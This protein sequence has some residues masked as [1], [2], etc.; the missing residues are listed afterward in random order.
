[1]LRTS[2]LTVFSIV[3]FASASY[4]KVWRVNN[5]T[6]VSADFTTVQ[7]A[8]NAAADGDTLHLEGSPTSSGA[9]SAPK[10]LVSVGPGYMLEDN[11]NTQALA[12]SAKVGTFT[13]NSGAAGSVVMG[14]DFAS[15]NIEVYA[16]GL[17]ISR[18]RFSSNSGTS[19]DY[20]SGNI[21]L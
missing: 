4:A 2:L 9:L 16:N 8:H 20:N 10:K 12:Q 21:Q 6:G 17:V 13:F 18:N 14:L 5:N 15:S 3:A 7:A 19:Y 1:M 11:P